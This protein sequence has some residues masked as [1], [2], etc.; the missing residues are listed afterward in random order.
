[1]AWSGD[2]ATTEYMFG[3]VRNTFEN[4]SNVEFVGILVDA[5]WR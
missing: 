3:H 5:G 2:H 1:V 4:R